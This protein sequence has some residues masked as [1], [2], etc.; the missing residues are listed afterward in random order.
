I[1]LGAEL[2]PACGLGER[3]RIRNEIKPGDAITMWMVRDSVWSFYD[4]HAS[5]REASNSA[6]RDG[7]GH[8]V[9]SYVEVVH[10][11]AELQFR[12]NDLI[13]FFRGQTTDYKSKWGTTL[14]PSLFRGSEPHTIPTEKELG[15]RF[16]HLERGGTVLLDQY[17]TLG[18][19]RLSRQR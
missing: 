15:R 2:A 10:K 13:L 4:R 1:C 16:A 14:K 5:A 17:E 3:A 12:N 19:T 7:M 8:P 6:I 9:A 18:R 11:V